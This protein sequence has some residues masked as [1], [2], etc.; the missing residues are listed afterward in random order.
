MSIYYFL[1]NYTI[2]GDIPINLV[3]KVNV[4]MYGINNYWQKSFPNYLY[5]Q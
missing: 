2:P 5:Q 4:L 1:I 3:L